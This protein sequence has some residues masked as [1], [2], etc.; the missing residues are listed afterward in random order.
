MRAK[1]NRMMRPHKLCSSMNNVMKKKKGRM[2]STYLTITRHRNETIV[3]LSPQILY[4][5]CY[6]YLTHII[7]NALFHSMA[8]ILQM[9]L[10]SSIQIGVNE[11]CDFAMRFFLVHQV[12]VLANCWLIWLSTTFTPFTIFVPT[13]VAAPTATFP[14][15]PTVIESKKCIAV[16]FHF[17]GISIISW[18]MNTDSAICYSCQLR[19]QHYSMRT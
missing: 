17:V 4:F 5:N 3:L 12:L 19:A 6:L 7:Y 13:T 16:Y 14:S 15:L 10:S 11:W 8:F 1:E 18:E 2:S 9:F